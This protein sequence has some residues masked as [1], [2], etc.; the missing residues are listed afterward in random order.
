M[1]RVDRVVLERR[2]GAP[3]RVVAFD[4]GPAA[5]ASRL[6]PT[7]GRSVE[8]L[9]H[10]FG[11]DDGRPVRVALADVLDIRDNVRVDLALGETAAGTIER[12]L[13]RWVRLFP[14]WS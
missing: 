2:P 11:V 13:R 6:S 10:A 8:G 7:L 4:I 12:R 9:E 1:G 5:L 14:E 3:L